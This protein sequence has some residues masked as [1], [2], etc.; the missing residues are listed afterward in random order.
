MK[1]SIFSHVEK[2]LFIKKNIVVKL[3]SFY[4]KNMN[5]G[6]MDANTITTIITTT[7]SGIQH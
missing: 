2:K 1:Q 3:D 6:K 4:E 7:S 5:N